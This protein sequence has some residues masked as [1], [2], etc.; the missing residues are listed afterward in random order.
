MAEDDVVSK[1]ETPLWK[2]TL[3]KIH[4]GRG[5]FHIPILTWIWNFPDGDGKIEVTAWPQ[6]GTISFDMCHGKK[7]WPRSP[8]VSSEVLRAALSISCSNF[9]KPPDPPSINEVFH[10]VLASRLIFE[11]EDDLKKGQAME[12]L[13]EKWQHLIS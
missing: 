12:R 1:K 6:L 7:F 2:M 5:I 10:D 4:D 9:G 8:F 3:R 13:A 11:N